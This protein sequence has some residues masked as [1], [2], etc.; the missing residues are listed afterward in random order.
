M[1]LRA[2]LLS[3]DT[4]SIQVLSTLLFKLQIA[5]ETCAE[6]FTAAKRLMD[7]KFDIVIVDWD[8]QQGSGWVLQSARQAPANRNSMTIALVSSKPAHGSFKMGENFVINK[9]IL[10][11][12]VESTLQIASSL[13]QNAAAAAEI[14]PVGLS[15]TE[16]RAF[17]S[18]TFS[19]QPSSGLQPQLSLSSLDELVETTS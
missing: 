13:L 3:K 1:S 8:D 14:Q 5:A 10:P 11:K 16:A 15:P 4:E 2:L 18:P 7:Q 17:Q 19:P 12:Q 6:P 9:P